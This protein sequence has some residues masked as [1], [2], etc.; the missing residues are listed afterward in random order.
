MEGLCKLVTL[1]QNLKMP[2]TCKKPFHMNIGAPLCKKKKRSKKHQIFE[3]E[4][5]ENRPSC[6][7]FCR[8]K[9][10]SRCKMDTLGQKLK[11]PKICKNPFYTLK[12]FVQKTARKNTKYSRNKTSLKI[13]HLAKV[14]AHAKAIAFAKW[15]LWVKS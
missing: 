8:W 9:G 13:G 5:F 15:S 11:T 6:K 7:G 12:L 3:N 10:Y 2:K 14:M 1:G 4:N